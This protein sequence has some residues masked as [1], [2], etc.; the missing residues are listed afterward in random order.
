M[1]KLNKS[2]TLIGWLL[3]ALLVVSLPFYVKSDYMMFNINMAGIYILLTLSLNFVLGYIGLISIG[4]AGFFAIGAYISAGL[5][6]GLYQSFWVGLVGAGLISALVG[7]IVGFPALRLKG[8]YFVLVTLG[9]GEIVRLVLLNWKSVTRGTDGIVNIPAPV[10]G[11]ISFDNKAQYYYLILFFVLL[12]SGV[13]WRIKNS[14]FGRSFLA[15][16]SSELAA[17]VM[18]VNTTETKMLAFSLSAFFAGI[19]GSLYAHL[20]SFISPE[21]FTVEES[22]LILCMLLVGGSG[23]ILGAIVGAVFLV[24]LQEWLRFLKEYYM[25]LFGAGIVAVMVFMPSGIVGMV[26]QWIRKRAIA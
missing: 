22:V 15:I 1:E 13:S 16:K 6:V 26:Q 17:E 18:G 20:F 10:L 11:P 3:L 14:K 24:F 8:H 23:S 5:T 21:V 7:I 12:A 19:A 4:H 9:F 25:I 2:L